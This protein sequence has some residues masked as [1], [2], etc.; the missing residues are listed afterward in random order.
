MYRHAAFA[1]SNKVLWVTTVRS[2]IWKSCN[3]TLNQWM[4]QNSIR[5]R[6][7]MSFARILVMVISKIQFHGPNLW[8]VWSLASNISFHQSTKFLV[9]SCKYR[10][11]ISKIVS[12]SHIHGHSTKY[13]TTKYNFQFWFSWMIDECSIAARHV[14][15]MHIHDITSWHRLHDWS[16][17]DCFRSKSFRFQNPHAEGM[18][19]AFSRHFSNAEPVSFATVAAG[20]RACSAW[21]G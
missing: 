18:F 15:S 13:L 12:N 5:F 9:L 4:N 21:F 1:S 20:F 17:T 7:H 16:V 10:E 14:V 6:L 3:C 8:F 19:F 2:W 11:N